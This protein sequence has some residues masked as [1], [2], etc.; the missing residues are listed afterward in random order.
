MTPRT[1]YYKRYR[2]EADLSRPPAQAVL[3]GGFYWLPWHDG[4]VD[5]H[6]DVKYL[7]FRGELDCQIFQ[8][9][10]TPLGCRELMRAIRT[11]DGFMPGATWLAAHADGCVG[12]VQGLAERG[13][14]GAIQTVGVLPGCRGLGLGEALLLKALHGFR[15]AGLTR[16]YLEV[17]ASNESAVLLY[18]KHGFRSSGTLYKA[19]EARDPIPV[20]AGI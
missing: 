1:R 9:F 18:R 13:R 11:R 10:Q 20:G 17:T 3:P 16:A 14:V 2:M 8:S 7:C 19:V 4:L 5:R 12:T 6:A 15:A